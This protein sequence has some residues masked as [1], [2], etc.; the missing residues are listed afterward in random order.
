M[1]AALGGTVGG[2]VG[3]ASGAF[4]AAAATS[5]FVPGVGP[6]WWQACWGATSL[7]RAELLPELLWQRGRAQS[8]HGLP[9]DDLYL[10]EDAL[11][12]GHSV[13]V[14]GAVD[15]DLA[16]HVRGTLTKAGAA[17]VDAARDD[18]WLGLQDPQREKYEG[19]FAN[20]R[21]HYRRG[22]ETAL[23]PK[24]RGRSL[25]ANGDNGQSEAESSPRHAF[26]SG[27][28]NGQAHQKSLEEKYRE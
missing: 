9:H 7:E 23:H 16:D 17:S 3:A 12:K 4:A 25:E 8:G 22:F 24:Q 15:A 11:R 13:L 27:Y 20:D 2:A 14:V 5:L 10:Y 26:R 28:K 18:W 19:D 21:V 6:I 1:G